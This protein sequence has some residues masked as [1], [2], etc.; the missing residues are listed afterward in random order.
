M[1]CRIQKRRFVYYFD[2]LQEFEIFHSETTAVRTTSAII[3]IL[4]R[5]NFVLKYRFE[6]QTTVS[7]TLLRKEQNM[8][9]N[10]ENKRFVERIFQLFKICKGK[11]IKFNRLA[12]S[13]FQNTRIFV[14][15]MQEGDN[16][17]ADNLE[18]DR[19]DLSANL[20]EDNR[21]QQL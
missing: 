4:F 17:Q 9:Q 15:F 7:D 19:F 13:V 1:K 11:T 8:F 14:G 5:Y 21:L 12:T 16:D 18:F 3:E 2:K 6:S 20:F 10:T